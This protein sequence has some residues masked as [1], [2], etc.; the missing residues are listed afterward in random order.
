M[1]SL[2]ATLRKELESKS[3]NAVTLASLLE[4][5]RSQLAS[6]QASAESRRYFST[7]FSLEVIHLISKQSFISS[8]EVTIAF[9]IR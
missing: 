5:L 7:E 9:L 1:R 4:L 3:E 2:V 6:G 8:K